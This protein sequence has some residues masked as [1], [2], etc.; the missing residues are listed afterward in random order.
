MRELSL[1]LS[2]IF[3]TTVMATGNTTS[4]LQMKSP[5]VI[6]QVTTAGVSTEK[7]SAPMPSIPEELGED[8]SL[9]R[10]KTREQEDT[11]NIAK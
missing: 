8:T 4:V 9:T 1:H 10:D 3:L 2:G 5:K 6:C 7:G 11:A